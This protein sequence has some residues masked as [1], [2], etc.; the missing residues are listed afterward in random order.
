MVRSR[1]A[2]AAAVLA[3]SLGACAAQV[4]PA[5]S[6]DST[7]RTSEPL[8]ISLCESKG[9]LT[10][11]MRAEGLAVDDA[12]CTAE[13]TDSRK[14]RAFGKWTFPPGSRDKSHVESVEIAVFADKGADGVSAFDNLKGSYPPH[15]Q[16]AVAGNYSRVANA[17]GKTIV[18]L[19]ELAEPLDITIATTAAGATD[20]EY[21]EIR[22]AHLR[23]LEQLVPVLTQS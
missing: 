20:T 16:R 11:W 8:R 2:V 22:A 9:D 23:A 19:P 5:S 6:V 15:E 21:A 14:L 3:V 1:G 13:S 10:S 4:S 7:T 17:R 12:K 18:N